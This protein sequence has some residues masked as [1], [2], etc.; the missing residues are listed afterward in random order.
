MKIKMVEK[1]EEIART[2]FDFNFLTDET[3]NKIVEKIKDIIHKNEGCARM[4]YPKHRY[5]KYT[6]E[7]Y[8]FKNNA[9]LFV[10]KD[11]EKKHTNIHLDLLSFDKQNPIYKSLA[12]QLTEEIK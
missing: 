4:I 7:L 1:L 8:E 6:V 10:I 11:F 2:K 3:E 5:A 12:R 9:V